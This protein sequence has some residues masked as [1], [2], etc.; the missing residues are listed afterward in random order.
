MQTF[1]KQVQDIAE[2][3]KG[4]YE[5]SSDITL[6]QSG[7]ELLVP[8]T[9]AFE[10]ESDAGGN[11]YV[12]RKPK[13]NQE[14][15]EI[16]D[17][18]ATFDEPIG[19][20]N[21][22]DLPPIDEPHSGGGSKSGGGKGKGENKITVGSKVKVKS[23][24]K[25]GIVTRVNPDGTYTVSEEDSG[26]AEFELAKGG[27][28]EQQIDSDGEVLGDFPEDELEPINDGGDGGDGGGDGDGGGGEGGG[29]GGGQGGGE[30]GG[31][32]G[33]QG[34]GEGGGED[35]GGESPQMPQ[36]DV[37]EIKER[38]NRL[39][40][41]RFKLPTFAKI[42]F[43][44]EVDKINYENTVFYKYKSRLVLYHR[45]AKNTLRYKNPM[46]ILEA[47]GFLDISNRFSEHYN[48]LSSNLKFENDGYFI[49]KN[50]QLKIFEKSNNSSGSVYNSAPSIQEYEDLLNSDY[51][52][53]DLIYANVFLNN[54]EE[55]ITM[56]NAYYRILSLS[57]F[58][59]PEFFGDDWLQPHLDFI[60]RYYNQSV[61]GFSNLPNGAFSNILLDEEVIYNMMS[62]IYPEG[63][64]MDVY[65]LIRD[66]D[67]DY[68]VYVCE[69][70][71]SKGSVTAN[72]VSTVMK[73][74]D[75]KLNSGVIKRTPSTDSSVWNAQY[76]IGD[77]VKIRFDFSTA[78]VD[79]VYTIENV[80]VIKTPFKLDKNGNNIG[81]FVRPENPSG[82][83]YMLSEN[84]GNWEGKDLEIA[85]AEPLPV[86]VNAESL[87][88]SLSISKRS[89]KTELI[90]NPYIIS[91]IVNDLC[92][93]YRFSVSL[94]NNSENKKTTLINLEK[95]SNLQIE[96]YVDFIRLIDLQTLRYGI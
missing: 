33:G 17:T 30:G 95:I 43:K 81:G 37:E 83:L 54:I 23:S 58:F 88:N 16:D 64:N 57:A 9:T 63:K 72:P 85:T 61:L 96:S 76:N 60:F 21:P 2:K 7:D 32:G 40:T 47:E 49:K 92:N 5:K 1:K 65:N 42:F 78:N 59:N 87:K 91:C 36:I 15:G 86:M 73:G 46:P 19:G 27:N 80:E 28:I 82:R 55:V 53:V 4:E 45:L 26:G 79:K 71:R 93:F 8:E 89:L 3:L 51:D 94:Q 67:N 11:A 13:G 31:E 50:E 18:G 10:G 66:I 39:K 34:G 6:F 69:N 24:G 74:N 29:Q 12:P 77:K 62:G 22:L 84:G 25:T 14:G 90:V 44:A 70:I 20:D 52:I 75:G 48:F 41:H 56:D 68:T 38:F 35:G